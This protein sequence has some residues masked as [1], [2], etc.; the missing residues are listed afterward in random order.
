MVIGHQ[1]SQLVAAVALAY[2]C[3]IGLS[4]AGANRQL[5]GLID[6]V[7]RGERSSD[8]RRIH[9]AGNAHGRFAERGLNVQIT[10]VWQPEHLDDDVQVR[11]VLDT[12]NGAARIARAA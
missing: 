6:I 10:S 8:Q 9:A 3:A 5:V 12:V 4:R 7:H 1:S 2:A 11:F